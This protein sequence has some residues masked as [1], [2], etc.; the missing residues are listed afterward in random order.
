[1][2]AV[3]GLGYVTAH[4]S[5]H[6]TLWVP[7]AAPA[8][9]PARLLVQVAVAEQLIDQR[10]AGEHGLTGNTEEAAVTFGSGRMAWPGNLRNAWRNGLLERT[11]TI[12]IEYGLIAG[13]G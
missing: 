3:R 10:L 13:M 6:R 4:T 12:C 1:M 7:P 9:L 8:C 11:R 2:I 5:V